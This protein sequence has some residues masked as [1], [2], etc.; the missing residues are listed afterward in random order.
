MQVLVEDYLGRHDEEL[1]QIE[2]ERRPGRPPSGRE[3]GLKQR[4][5]NEQG[6][7]VSGFWIP[8]LEDMENLQKLKDWDGKWS[9]LATLIFVRVT[10]D[11]K[12]KPSSFP[13]KGMS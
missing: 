13:P 1:A 5:A 6:E 12:K 3:T 8:D 7:Y 9:S 10:K 11:C 2:A 4:Q